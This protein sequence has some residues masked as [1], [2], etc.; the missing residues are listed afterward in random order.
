[1]A[2]RF[3]VDGVAA[4]EARPDREALRDMELVTKHCDP[5]GEEEMRALCTV[6]GRPRVAGRLTYLNLRCLPFRQH[7]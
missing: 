3:D 7:Y 6:L 5:L 1:V 4:L 2:Q